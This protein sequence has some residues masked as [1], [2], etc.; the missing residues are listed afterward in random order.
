M[1]TTTAATIQI[2]HTTTEET[3]EADGMTEAGVIV[4]TV[5]VIGTVTIVET[6]ATTV[7]TGVT[8]AETPVGIGVTRIGARAQVEEAPGAATIREARVKTRAKQ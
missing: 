6:E 5:G 7:A 3:I 2:D 1:T 8:T 4:G